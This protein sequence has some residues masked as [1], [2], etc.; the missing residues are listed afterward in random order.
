MCHCTTFFSLLLYSIVHF[1]NVQVAILRVHEYSTSNYSREESLIEK[2]MM[3][4][5]HICYL[6]VDFIDRFPCVCMRMLIVCRS[7]ESAFTV[8][9]MNFLQIFMDVC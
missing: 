3:E 4:K 7:F 6:L 1:L 5:G 8:L 9:E 2:S